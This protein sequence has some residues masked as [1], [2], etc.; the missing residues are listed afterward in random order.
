[1]ASSSGTDTNAEH[2]QVVDALMARSA[3]RFMDIAPLL[4]DLTDTPFRFLQS[5]L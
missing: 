3:S 2:Q 4:T 1:M 5:P